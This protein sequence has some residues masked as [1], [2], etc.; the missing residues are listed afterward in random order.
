MWYSVST[1][2]N[3]A[4]PSL[5][6]ALETAF[7]KSKSVL[8]IS[9]A[10]CSAV[11]KRNNLYILFDSHSHGEDCLSSSDGTSILMSFSCLEDL[12]AYLYA[13][14]ESMRI[15][16]TMQ[17]DLLPISVRKKGYFCTQEKPSENL[18]EAYFYDQ[19][20]R[21][22]QKAV[23]T[24]KSEPIL[25]AKKKKDRKE[26]YRIYRQN[27]RQDRDYKAKELLAQRKHMHKA[28]QDKDYK[29]KELVAQ[30]KSKQNA[31]QDRGYKVKELVAQRKSKQNARQDRGYKAK[32]LVAQ[33][34]SKQNARQ[35]RD[36]K[37]K[38]LLAQRKNMH[39]ARQD[40]DYKAKELLAQRKHMHKARQELAQI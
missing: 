16:L 13:F 31:R 11:H 28:R 27:A 22:K 12:I 4:L 23:T 3:Q 18:L 8:L 6:C 19:T 24:K 2:E 34:K 38:E 36:Y 17:F 25:N 9:G 14:Y 15:D 39:K 26:Y 35:D 20:L 32:E 7:T 30:R 10:V 33:R 37:A 1:I 5:H 40:R 21:Q 29:A